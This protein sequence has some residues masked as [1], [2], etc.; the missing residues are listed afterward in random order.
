MA[1]ETPISTT[2]PGQYA[3]KRWGDYSNL[4]IEAKYRGILQEEMTGG[5]MIGEVLRA[6][7][8]EHCK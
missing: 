5:E 3:T 4:A 6:A 8:S 7:G 1:T 2:E